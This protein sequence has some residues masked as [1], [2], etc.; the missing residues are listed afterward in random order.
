M[1]LEMKQLFDIPGE[2]KE[3]SF[4]ISPEELKERVFSYSFASPLAVKGEAFNRAGVVYVEFS[5]CF[6]LSQV[7]DRCLAEF[8]REYRYEFSHICVRDS[9][10]TDELIVVSDNALDLN[11]LAVSDSLLELPT[12]ILCREDCKG[13]CFVCGQNLNEGEC[14]CS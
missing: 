11:E 2:R 10:T 9:S 5:C 7:C 12:K 4:E 8:E 1:I 3:F 14:S 13:M 6:A